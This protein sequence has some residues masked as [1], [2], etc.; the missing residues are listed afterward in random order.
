ML[1]ISA[2]FSRRFLILIYRFYIRR[3]VL[4]KNASPLYVTSARRYDTNQ[5][6][7]VSHYF[8]TPFMEFGAFHSCAGGFIYN[9]YFDMNID[10]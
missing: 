3:R 6:K 9:I 7:R 5:Y 2:P 1:Q 4:R 10:S 8:R